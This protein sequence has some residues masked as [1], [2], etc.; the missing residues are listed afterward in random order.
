MVNFRQF[1]GLDY[2][3]DKV[4]VATVLCLIGVKARRV[5]NTLPGI[6]TNND[7]RTTAMILEAVRDYCTPRAN[8]TYER[9]I[10]RTTTQEDRPFDVFLTELRHKASLCECGLIKDSIIRDQIVIGINNPESTR[11]TSPR[12][13]LDARQRHPS[14]PSVGTVEGIH[15]SSHFKQ[16]SAG[17]RRY[18]CC[19]EKST[20]PTTKQCQ[21]NDPQLQVL[22]AIARAR[23][24]QGFWRQVP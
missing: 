5:I 23:E 17:R 9:F 19:Q 10:F 3:K 13:R 11:T 15:Q 16:L 1:N 7:E 20:E 4:R 18:R 6:P 2:C 8:V 22:L 12:T 24:L 21:K 14:L